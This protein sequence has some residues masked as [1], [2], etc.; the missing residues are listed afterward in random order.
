MSPIRLKMVIRADGLDSR[1][2]W[3]V[4]ERMPGYA[5]LSCTIFTGRQH[6]I[7]VH[8]AA[9]GHAIVGDKLYGPDDGLFTRA[10]AQALDAD[11]LRALE[12]NRHALHNHRLVFRTPA[13]GESVE[14]RSPLAPDLRAFLDARSP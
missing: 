8:L 12:L 14:V 1:T 3:S 10:L 7:R 11:D 9:M 13:G 6:Q 5:L 2:D 4:V